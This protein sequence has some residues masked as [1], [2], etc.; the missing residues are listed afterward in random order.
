M[1]KILIIDNFDSFTY[2][3]FY[4]IQNHYNG[5]VEVKRDNNI[6]LDEVEEYQAIVI[7]PGPGNPANSGLSMAILEKYHSTK[8]FL[9]VCLGMQ[10]INKF[11]EGETI[12][13]PYPVHGKQREIF[14]IE[15]SPILFGIN[16]P[17]LV[18]RY[19]SLMI[20][21]TSPDLLI[22]AE[23][24]E[25]IPMII[26]HKELPIFG[27]QFH[28]ESFMTPQG[29]QMIINFLDCVDSYAK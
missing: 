27:V 24:N 29:D 23:S 26:E 4:L 1:N 3:L 25:K 6:A 11:F 10:C 2:N 5:I 22:V 8:P 13:S 7:S 17:L 28:P 9:G 18:A 14:Q 12:R 21:V 20:K 15:D 16:S 19:H